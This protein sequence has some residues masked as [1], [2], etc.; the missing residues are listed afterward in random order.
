MYSYSMQTSIRQIS[1]VLVRGVLTIVVSFCALS[2]FTLGHTSASWSVADEITGNFVAAGHWANEV[3]TTYGEVIINEVHWAGSPASSRD[4]WIELYNRTDR[5]ISLMNWTIENA[6]HPQKGLHI[7]GNQVIPAGGYLLL[8]ARNPQSNQ[9]A[10][11]VVS[12][13][14]NGSLYLNRANYR[15][16]VLRDTEGTVIDET[17][18]NSPWP[19][20]E[21]EAEKV[22]ASMQRVDGTYQQGTSTDSWHTCDPETVD[23]S[24]WKVEYIGEYTV[25][26]VPGQSNEAAEKPLPALAGLSLSEKTTPDKEQDNVAD[27]AGDDGVVEEDETDEAEGEITVPEGEQLNTEDALNEIENETEGRGQAVIE[28]VDTE[29]VVDGDVVEEDLEEDQSTPED[30]VV[31]EEPVEETQTGPEE[32]DSIDEASEETEDV[33]EQEY[34]VT[35]EEVPVEEV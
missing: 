9:S 31:P 25:C 26:G 11:A 20:G 33:V 16:L 19:A 2:V 8:T 3:P 28:P 18:A 13:T 10:L 23:T 29:E 4:Q 22:Y 7:Q 5:E 17:P 24:L 34:E 30:E 15:P 32:E 14:Q 6:G 21:Y 12:H 1:I 35:A 27:P